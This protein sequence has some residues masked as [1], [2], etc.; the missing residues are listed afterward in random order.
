MSIGEKRSAN[1]MTARSLETCHV[2]RPKVV[3][4]KKNFSC[5]L[6]SMGFMK[7]KVSSHLEAVLLVGVSCSHTRVHPKGVHDGR[8]R[9]VERNKVN[10]APFKHVTPAEIVYCQAIEAWIFRHTDIATAEDEQDENKCSWLLKT[11]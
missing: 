3:F 2:G 9:Y 1:V 6:T 4:R 7:K 11:R 8:S 5:F 10:G